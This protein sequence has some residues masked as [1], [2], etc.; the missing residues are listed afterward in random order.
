M[1]LGVVSIYIGQYL[2]SYTGVRRTLSPPLQKR[3]LH[4]VTKVRCNVYPTVCI[5]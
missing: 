5:S 3:R 4:W 2:L 1:S